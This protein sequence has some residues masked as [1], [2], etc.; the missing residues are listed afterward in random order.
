MRLTVCAALVAVL[1]A[2]GCA[3][4]PAVEGV[5]IS[6]LEGGDMQ[7]IIKRIVQDVRGEL[8]RILG[9]EW[10]KHSP[11]VDAALD[12]IVEAA[13]ARI[14]ASGVEVTSPDE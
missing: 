8:A 6:E 1:F 11:A 10:A 14:K 9:D 4:L 5:V 2:S 12:R 13:I 7:E 3:L